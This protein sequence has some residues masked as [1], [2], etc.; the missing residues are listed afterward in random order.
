MRFFIT[1]YAARAAALEPAFLGSHP[2]FPLLGV[3][4]TVFHSVGLCEARRRCRFASIL[5]TV[6]AGQ[7]PLKLDALFI[8][9]NHRAF[10]K[11]LFGVIV[12][13][14]FTEFYRVHSVLNLGST[15]SQRSS[16]SVISLDR[17]TE[18]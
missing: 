15:D 13:S 11:K 16:M 9:I 8:F 4:K 5:L 10:K 2:L 17:S 1:A 3:F 18:N 7:R 14:F 6:P 12:F